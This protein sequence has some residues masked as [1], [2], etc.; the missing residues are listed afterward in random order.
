MKNNYV[1]KVDLV[2]WTKNGAKTLPRVLRRIEKVIPNTYINNKIVV[3]DHS[4]DGTREIARGFGWSIYLNP[5]EGIGFGAN[6]ALKYVETEYFASVKQDVLLSSDWWVKITRHMANRDV[7]VAQGIRLFSN[8]VLRKLDTTYSA[9]NL[10]PY[11]IDN[12]LISHAI[13]FGDWW[14]SN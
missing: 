9:Q 3:D 8:D 10:N 14:F 1:K 5:K 11:S 13:S 7:V 2:M 6:E 12:N 4:T